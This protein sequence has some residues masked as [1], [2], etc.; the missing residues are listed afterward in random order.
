MNYPMVLKRRGR[1]SSEPFDSEKLLNSIKAACLSVRLTD[2]VAHDTALQ[3]VKQVENWAKDKS[4][5]TSAD[6]R[7]V[8]GDS[9]SRVSPEAG[10]LY[11]HHKS[12]M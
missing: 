11:Q 5:V 4:E 6:I 3:A 9:L 10:Y 8:A 1:R 2:G 7:R 12:I